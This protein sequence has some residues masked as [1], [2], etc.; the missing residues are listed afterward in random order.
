[1]SRPWM[2]L[3]V[4]DYLADTRHLST[5]EHGAYILMIMHYWQ[6]GA[7]PTEEARLA[8]IAG[9]T[10]D[11]WEGSRETL[12]ALFD[13]GWKHKRIEFELTEAARISEAG[14]RGGLASGKARKNKGFEGSL[15]DRSNDRATIGQALPSPSQSHKKERTD[16]RAVADATRPGGDEKFEEFWQVYPSRGQ[17]ANPK[18]PARD[19]FNRLIK[20]G[21]D[22]GAIIAGAHRYREAEQ[23]RGTLGTDKIAQAITWLN[24]ERWKDYAATAGPAN[25]WSKPPPEYLEHLAKQRSNGHAHEGAPIRSDSGMG[26]DGP[27]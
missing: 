12:A 2:P 4:G 19:R 24:Q 8:R 13:D 11:E 27:N 17:A 10:A 18:K 22:P 20:S 9:L 23:R 6:T 26:Q 3:Y 5:L 14:R 21:C 1:M 7:L 15:N 16:S 25:D